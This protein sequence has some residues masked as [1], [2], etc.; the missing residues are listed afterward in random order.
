MCWLAFAS[1][2]T[3]FDFYAHSVSYYFYD[4]MLNKSDLISEV[5]VQPRYLLLSL[6][7]EFFSRIGLP[8]GFVASVLL[9]LPIYHIS[10]YIDKEARYN[11]YSLFQIILIWF[12]LFLSIFYS[13]LS[14]VILW[15]F[16]FTLTKNRLFLLGALFHPFG[17]VL[18]FFLWFFLSPKDKFYFFKMI[19]IFYVLLYIL[20]E[21]QLFTS[22]DFEKIRYK[23]DGN[24]NIL[25]LLSM[26]YDRKKNELIQFLVICI[27]S[28]ASF[29]AS[30]RGK[31]HKILGIGGRIFLHKFLLNISLVLIYLIFFLYMIEKVTFIN[32]FFELDFNNVMYASWFDFG[33][34]DL[35]ISYL[36]L[37]RE[38]Y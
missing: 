32:S 9:L 17:I 5:I 15:L 7:Y 27:L 16:A 11:K 13:G 28:W 12:I 8:L 14:L 2:S 6:I 31:P 3:G 18:G 10:K 26:A 23:I 21:S 37:Y 4:E 22:V 30:L 24:L 19:F 25:D 20:T 38:R 33:E 1:V 29:Q 35:K 34:K 36:E